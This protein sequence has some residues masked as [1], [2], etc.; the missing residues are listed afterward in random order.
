MG[1]F[2]EDRQAA[3]KALDVLFDKIVGAVSVLVEKDNR[4]AELEREAD[5][6]DKLIRERNRVLQA[7]GCD[8]HGECVPGA[9]EK[10]AELNTLARDRLELLTL[11]CQKV[12]ELESKLAE[13]ERTVE[14]LIQEQ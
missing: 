1:S 5:V 6:S 8:V 11:S 7:L 14:D 3:R 2:E 10:V 13:S 9:L 12:A 4:I